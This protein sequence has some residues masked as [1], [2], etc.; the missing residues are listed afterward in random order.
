MAAVLAVA[1]P[2]DVVGVD[3]SEGFLA[4]ARARIVDPRA[5]FRI[6]DARSLPLADRGFDA[7]VSELA[8]S[9]VSDPGRAV[10][11][12]ARVATPG[13]MVAAY[14]WDYAEG[15]AMMRYFWDAARALDPA[16]AELDEGGAFRCAGP[17]RCVTCGQ[18]PVW[19]R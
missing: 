14:V 11:E 7:V 2:T 17:S 3:L 19:I 4:Y 6:G 8:L 16:A 13:G 18:T 15:M 1:D 9:F 12:L 10:A 5:A